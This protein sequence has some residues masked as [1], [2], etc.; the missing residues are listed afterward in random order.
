MEMDRRSFMASLFA[1][2][3]V[4]GIGSRATVEIYYEHEHYT[5]REGL[6]NIWYF[7]DDFW[8]L[9][10][11]GNRKPMEFES[12]SEAEEFRQDVGY[13]KAEKHYRPVSNGEVR[14]CKA[15]TKIH[16]M[17][18]LRLNQ[19]RIDAFLMLWPVEDPIARQVV[20]DMLS[21]HNGREQS[22]IWLAAALDN[23]KR[24][25]FTLQ[26][27]VGFG[28]LLRGIYCR[29]EHD[30]YHSLLAKLTCFVA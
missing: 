28:D 13:V 1:G 25:I 22:K 4:T 7:H 9:L 18:F 5:A 20:I 19:E 6:W 8:Y 30:S 23:N 24:S 14:I 12:A 10:S 17:H 29:S 3:L 21:A 2:I 27:N 11:D 26:G 16:P 15:P